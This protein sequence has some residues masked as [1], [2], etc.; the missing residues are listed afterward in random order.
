MY[1]IGAG[2]DMNLNSD[3]TVYKAGDIVYVLYRNPHTQNV[4]NVQQA[5]VVNNPENP[6]ELAVF[7]YDT[8][9]PLSNEMAVYPN[10]VEAEQA[11]RYY[12]E[13]AG[14]AGYTGDVDNTGDVVEGILE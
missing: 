13:D 6:N 8:Y 12:F 9:Y 2:D 7:L 1:K 4:A 3:N 11:Y 10:E 14:D 5:A